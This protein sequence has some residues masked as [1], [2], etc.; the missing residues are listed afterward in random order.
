MSDFTTPMRAFSK[1]LLFVSLLLPL[2]LRAQV[3]DSYFQ[4][5]TQYNPNIATP[6][7]FLGHQIGEWH[8]THDQLVAYMKYLSEAS[9]RITLR[10]IGRT[11]ENRPLLLLTI[12]SPDNHQNLENIKQAHA[13]LVDPELSG[14]L[15]LNN[16]PVVLYLGYSIHG[17]EA[18]GSNAAPVIAYEMAASQDP[19]LIN[20]LEQTIVLL[21]P[22]LNPD[23]LQRFST[24]V[25]SHKSI[26][27]PNADPWDREHDE[28]WPNGRTNHYW[29]D[30]NRD[31]MP[32]QHPESQA[33]IAQ[34]HSWFPNIL[35]DAHEMGTNGTYFFQPGVESRNN[36]LTPANT[37]VLTEKIA[38]YHAK[39]LDS[40]GSLY[41]S[42]EGFDDYY[43]GKGSSY[44]DVNGAV[45]ILFEQA[46][47][48]GHVQESENGN[49]T[50]P[51]AIRNHIKTTFSTWQ[52][53]V[54][55]RTDLLSHQ[56]EFFQEAMREARSS[57]TKAYAFGSTEDPRRAENLVEMLL[58]HRVQVFK[59]AD[60]GPGHFVVPTE[61]P[62]YRFVTGLF[63]T[64]TEFQD[65]LFYDVSTWTMPL[66]FNLN[67]EVLQGRGYNPRRLGN[68]VV[69][70]SFTQGEVVGGKSTYAYTF[71]PHGFYSHRAMYRLLRQ[72]LR[73]EVATEPFHDGKQSFDFGAILV[74]VANQKLNTDEIYT[75]MQTIA[76]EDGIS[77][78]A[79]ATGYTQG[80]QL[81]SPSMVPLRKPSIAI[82][83]GDGVSPYEVGEVW[84]LFDQ[85]LGIPITLL[86]PEN[87][88]RANL[89]RYNTM[90][91]VSGSIRINDAAKEKLKAWVRNGGTLVGTRGA[92]RWLSSQ[93]FAKTTFVSND[94]NTNAPLPYHLSSRYRGAQVIGGSIF[95]TRLDLTHPLAY[96]YTRD[97]LPV[98]R[99]HSTMMQA[100]KNPY[101]NPV[102][103][104]DNPLLS[105]YISEPNL[106]RL[107]GT[108]AAQVSS[109]G[110]GRVISL[111]DNPNF[112]AFWLGTNRLF[113]NSIFFGHIISG[114][115]TE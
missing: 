107:G 97:L 20:R 22:S 29:F 62:Q 13:Q 24:W 91:I 27:A 94:N 34:F 10:E 101:A 103:Y 98:F 114:S 39:A 113:L 15:N 38:Q 109:L 42:R 115:T 47:S 89:D 25:N 54:D 65:S 88:G 81:G 96:G 2:Q 100:A 75:L 36:P 92:V 23:G 76:T 68:R 3:A 17:N 37:Y 86:P 48:R 55:L 66:A 67:F 5:S 61:Q 83:A 104:T 53:S 111:V 26:S 4:Q 1:F 44:P 16:M 99:N 14:S 90:V 6:R 85:K 19:E 69:D 8:I 41:Y 9:D 95:Q 11:H 112:R 35:I 59:D 80:L 105:G 57:D 82:L 18:S 84:H 7:Q 51:F 78:Y 79:Q 46:S 31:W 32:V 28:V 49:L 106:A 30:L 73:I 50:F 64:R 40:I 58:Q 110:R 33:R 71:Q 43:L 70:V 56:R 77:S 93:G 63:E 60:K 12:T 87:L 45:G 21:D 102:R 74:P 108:A 72:G 52:A